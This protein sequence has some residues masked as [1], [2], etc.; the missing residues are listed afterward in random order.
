MSFVNQ[1]SINA[2]KSQNIALK[3]KTIGQ[4]P[5]FIKHKRESHS[6]NSTPQLDQSDKI[7]KINENFRR[8]QSATPSKD[9]SIL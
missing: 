3:N 2:N 1:A 8:R 4:I 7:A 5:E 6:L 9:S